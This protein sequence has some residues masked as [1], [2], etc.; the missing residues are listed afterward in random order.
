MMSPCLPELHL[1]K[2][3][4]YQICRVL[5]SPVTSFPALHTPPGG[6][7]I[8]FSS[9]ADRKGDA[10]PTGEGLRP[11]SDTVA[12]PSCHRTSEQPAVSQGFPLWP[13]S[14]LIIF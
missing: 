13:S 4:W 2:H 12:S 3:L 10:D 14:I 8:Q 5:S 9:G 1:L 7:F 11:T 6:P